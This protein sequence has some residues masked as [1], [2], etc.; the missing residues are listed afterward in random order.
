MRQFTEESENSTDGETEQGD[1]PSTLLRDV[2]L[3][4]GLLVA[5]LLLRDWRRKVRHAV[6]FGFGHFWFRRLVLR[7]TSCVF[8]FRKGPS[9]HLRMPYV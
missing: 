5:L 2:L 7:S 6:R 4:T 8:A 9:L 3:G 1:R